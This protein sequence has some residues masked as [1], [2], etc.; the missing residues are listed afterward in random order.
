[1]QEHKTNAQ[2]KMSSLKCREISTQLSG[3]QLSG[4]QAIYP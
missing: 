3:T 4:V 1:L 2:V